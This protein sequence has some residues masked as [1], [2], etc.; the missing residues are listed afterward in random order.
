MESLSK[1]AVVFLCHMNTIKN[2]SFWCA[3]PL[4]LYICKSS[5]S[6]AGVLIWGFFYNLAEN[7]TNKYF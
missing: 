7:K 2:A 1:N 5:G 3:T 6:K 4:N